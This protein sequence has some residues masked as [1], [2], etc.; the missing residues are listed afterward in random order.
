MLDQP[1]NPLLAGL[2]NVDFYWRS[3]IV[4]ESGDGTEQISNGLSQK[5]R[6]GTEY[7]VHVEGSKDLLFQAA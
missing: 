6:F 7:V 5:H 2:N 4:S 1:A 3:L